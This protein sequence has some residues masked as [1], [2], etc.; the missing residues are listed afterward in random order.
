MNDATPA[1]SHRD[2]IEFLLAA[3]SVVLVGLLIVL[4]FALVFFKIVPDATEIGLLMAVITPTV[5]L[6]IA[7]Y[8]FFY[9]SSKGSQTANATIAATA[10]APADP[11]AL[12]SAATIAASKG[13]DAFTAY[14]A[15]LSPSELLALKP[16]MADLTAKA[17]AAPVALKI[18]TP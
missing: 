9:G 11:D 8:A 18:T 14:V 1:N 13:T 4:V 2:R 5:G 17:L 7:V 6:A 12:L 10:T 15:T 16:N 3:S